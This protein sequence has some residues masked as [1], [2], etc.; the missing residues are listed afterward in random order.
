MKALIFDVDGTLAE[1]EDAHRRSFNQAFK[2]LG[3]PWRWDETTNVRLLAVSGGTERL[4][5]FQSGLPEAE[6]LDHDTLVQIHQVKRRA[7]AALL[8][9]GRLTF[10]PGVEDLIQTARSLGLQLAVATAASRASLEVLFDGCFGHPVEDMFDT[11]V[12]GDDVVHKK[13]DPESYLLALERLGCAPA[14]A[15]VFEDSPVGFASARAA[16][17]D[18]VVTP[19]R[20]GPQDGDFTGAVAV[21][22]SLEREN[23]PQFGFPPEGCLPTDQK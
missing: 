4:A 18:V 9:K 2:D 13:P 8:A 20:H 15:L 21:L 11:V 16:G 7:Y 12:T 23:W 10:R 5:F 22:A 3:L 6:R 1:T 17:L 14:D 19:S